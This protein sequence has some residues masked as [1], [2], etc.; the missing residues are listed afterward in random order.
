MEQIVLPFGR[1]DQGGSSG[2]GEETK[3]D[4]QGWVRRPGGVVMGECGAGQE[5]FQKCMSAGI[6]KEK[7]I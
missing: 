2:V 3:G 6:F 1:G 5:N 7:C 4:H